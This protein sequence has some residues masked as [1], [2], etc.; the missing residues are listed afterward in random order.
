[1]CTCAT[2]TKP[3]SFNGYLIMCNIIY[4]TIVSRKS[5]HG[6]CTLPW[7]QTGGWANIRAINI[8]IVV[9]SARSGANS[10]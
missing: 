7:A 8:K 5:A 6:R 2:C 9:L 10:A 3:L 4:N 1:M